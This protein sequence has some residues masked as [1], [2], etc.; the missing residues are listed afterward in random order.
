MSTLI[1]RCAQAGSLESGDA[2]VQV[3]PSDGEKLA[4][5]IKSKVGPR[6]SKS[7]HESVH[8][9]AEELGVTAAAVEIVDRGALDF[10]LR[11]RVT[12]ALRRAMEAEIHE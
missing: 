3:A 9:V 10:V 1:K 6:F 4:L 11:A 2:L 5:H 8:A 7:M 12:T